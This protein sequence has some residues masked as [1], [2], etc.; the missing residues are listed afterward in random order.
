MPLTGISELDDRTSIEGPY[1]WLHSPE[2]QEAGSTFALYVAYNLTHVQGL[3]VVYFSK[4][5]GIVALRRFRSLFKEGNQKG[6]LLVTD[7]TSLSEI[8]DIENDAYDFIIADH[9]FGGYRAARDFCNGVASLQTPILV[10][11]DASSLR[12]LSIEPQH[13]ASLVTRQLVP[14]ENEK[15]HTIRILKNRLGERDFFY[16]DLPVK[17][18]DIR[19]PTRWEHLE[20][21]EDDA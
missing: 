5:G 17:G 4:D 9:V 16:L 18:P 2:F 3:K 13:R 14:S 8:S 6:T 21:E 19:Y 7:L 11:E 10:V 20:D 15:R 12:P 1:L